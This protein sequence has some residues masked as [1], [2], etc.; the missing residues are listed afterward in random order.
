MVSE[1]SPERLSVVV[2]EKI[3]S[4]F[5]PL[6][7]SGGGDGHQW[8]FAA[9]WPKE[10]VGEAIAAAD[11]LICSTVDEAHARAAKGLR[12]LHVTGAGYEKIPLEAL[13]PHVTVANTFG[14]G[15]SIAEHVIMASLM[16]SRRALVVNR[17]MRD[18][19]WHTVN[20]DP[21]LPLQSTLEGKVLGIVGLGS[22]GLEVAD[23][24]DRFGMQ[25]RA[26]RRTVGGTKPD[27]VSRIDPIEGLP[28]LLAA[29]DVVVVAIPFND[30]TRGLI[31]AEALG[32]MKSSGILI[33][34]ARGPIVDEDA[35]FEA[36]SQNRI[37]GAGIDVWWGDRHDAS[38]PA[39][40]LPFG[41]LDNVVLTPHH[42]G[43]TVQT[44]EHRARD[45]SHNISLLAAGKPLINV[46]REGVVREGAQTP[47]T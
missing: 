8:T 40:R 34:V 46:V 1:P 17:E 5:E 42:S 16:M 14:H 12:L 11:V 24:A 30:S 9:D 33:N 19:V 35:L 4:R 20:S 38:S 7:T 37:G 22:I 47:K 15:R 43:H 2:T 10:R 45:I 13:N 3:I 26:V 21:D 44:F 41:E 39:S 31:G 29:S 28:E 27:F 36:L 23:L 6:L 25:V 32:Q 18:G